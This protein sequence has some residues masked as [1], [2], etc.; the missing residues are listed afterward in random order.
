MTTSSLAGDEHYFKATTLGSSVSPSD[1][2]GLLHYSDAGPRLRYSNGTYPR[3]VK[4]W[5]AVVI[6]RIQHPWRRK[7][8]LPSWDSVHTV[9]LNEEGQ[10]HKS[11]HHSRS[12]LIRWWF[13]M[14]GWMLAAIAGFLCF[15]SYICI[16]LG[17]GA[18]SS[19]RFGFCTVKPFRPQDLCP[20]E[21]WLSWG[22]GFVGFSASVGLGTV[23]ASLSAWLVNHYAPAA[24]GSGI[25][26]VKTILNGCVL[27]DVVTLRTLCIKV[28][29]L[30]LAVASGMALGH[31]GPMVHVAVCWA[32]FLSTLFPQ[33]QNEGKRRELFSAAVAG[34]ISSSFGTP[35]GGVLFSLE[36]VSSRFPSRTLLLAFIAS[37]VATL[38]LS[39]SNLF[40]TGHL[41]L[42]SVIHCNMS[43]Q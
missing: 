4:S 18:L 40:G 39:I 19:I 31:E 3:G 26:E 24:S 41:T 38:A 33:Y 37:V 2:G 1:E 15:V 23:M 9:E 27:P 16:E 8:H 35:V 29:C 7:Q 11:K 5:C 32:Q 21:R 22:D 6:D 42:F 34:G 25:P 13:A 10:L 28:P 17:V 30:V 43:S 12:C 14:Q 20:V 36:E